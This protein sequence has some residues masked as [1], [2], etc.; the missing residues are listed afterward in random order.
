MKTPIGLGLRVVRGPDWKWLDQDDGEGSTGTVV[1]VC[2]PN[3]AT[4]AGRSGAKDSVIVQWDT[5]HRVSY[6]CGSEAAYDLRVIDNAQIG[7]SLSTVMIV[8]I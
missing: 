7:E 4:D 2:G 6:R 8:R 1:D 3:A 5:G